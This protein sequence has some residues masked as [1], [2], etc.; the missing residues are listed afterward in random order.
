VTKSF[1][2]TNEWL[3]FQESIGHKVW[4]FDNG[5]II[6]NI[7]RHDLPFG[8]NYLYVP[9]GPEIDLDQITGG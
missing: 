2:Q 6:A 9:H 1:L 7:I 5:K 3:D 8:K 4:R